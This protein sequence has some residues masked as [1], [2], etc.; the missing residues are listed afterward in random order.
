VKAPLLL[1]L[2][3][4]LLLFFTGLGDVP[5]YTRGEPREALVAREMRRTG[6]WLVPARPDGELTRKPPVFYWAAAAALTLLP[7]RPELAARLPSALLA[8]AGVLVTWAVVHASFG[9]APAFGAALMLATTLEWI[10]AAT[11]ARVDMA[12]VAGLTLLFGAWLLVLARDL[13]R[14][15]PALL[16]M[17]VAGAAIATLAKGPV[18]LV[19]PA[20]VVGALIALRRDPSPLRRLGAIPV[21]VLGGAIAALWYGAAFAK[22]GWEF[23][24]I[25]AKENWLRYVDSEDAGTGHA[26]GL[27]YLPLVGL[28][29]LMPWTPLL[30]LAGAPFTDR[31]RRTPALTFA[32]V[33]VAVTLV[34]FSLADAKRSVYLLPLFPALMLLLALGVER[35]PAGRLAFVLRLT[36]ALYPPVFALL[37]VAAAAL[38]S[39]TDVVALLRPWLKPRDA[40]NTL[41][42]V[43][44]ARSAAP[45][46]LVLAGMALAGAFLMLRARR[47]GDWQR[48]VQVVAALTVAW[49]AAIGIWLRPPIGRAASL[50]PFMARVGGLVPADATLYAF[51]TP[52][53]GLRFYAP[54]PLE[55]WRAQSRGPAYLLLWEDERQRWRDAQ[56]KP[57]EPLAVSEAEQSRRGPLTLVVV[58]AETSLRAG[59]PG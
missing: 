14:P 4:C 10:R 53:A 51:F 39:G 32:A 11:I 18:A 49:T 35:P 6:E 29:G 34:F 38:A 36:T 54:R 8:T 50:Q 24:D 21:L 33:W 7:E 22:H 31:T 47:A 46:L 56:G 41:A 25:V 44:V 45:V 37:G 59:G 13:E 1:L 30:P 23:F 26:H 12:L 20:L 55:P 15:G 52:D 28:I 48:L 9:A 40:Q 3:A 17:A 57:L 42:I 5:F 43:S 2:L 19:L 16:A 58:P 27:L